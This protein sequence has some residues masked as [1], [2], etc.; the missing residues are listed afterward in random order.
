M[1]K[2]KKKKKN[3][4]A[5]DQESVSET[6]MRSVQSADTGSRRV[7]VTEKTEQR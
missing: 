4:F 7:T 3:F 1:K 6:G 5:D 2:L